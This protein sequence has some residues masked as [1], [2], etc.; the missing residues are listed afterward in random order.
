M[1]SFQTVTESWVTEKGNYE[2]KVSAS[3]TDIK[4]TASFFVKKDWVIEKVHRSISPLVPIN[5]LTK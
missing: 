4:R 5:E 1:A 3:S 2:L